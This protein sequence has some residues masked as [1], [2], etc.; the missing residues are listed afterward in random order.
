MSNNYIQGNID[1]REQLRIKVGAL[2][3]CFF[4]PMHA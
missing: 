2:N 1:T 3:V 4:Q